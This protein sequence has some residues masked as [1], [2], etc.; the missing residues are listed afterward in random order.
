MVDT[1]VDITQREFE[2]A[3][4]KYEWKR[5]EPW[6]VEEAVYRIEAGHGFSV[7]IYSTISTDTG[8]SREKGTDAIRALLKYKGEKIVANAPKTLRTKNWKKN[9]YAKIDELMEMVTEYK[10]PDG[11]PM[12]KRKR[13]DGKGI[14]YGC[15]L[16][17]KC[18]YIYKGE[19]PL[20]KLY[21][22]S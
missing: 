2:K 12:V 10:D 20:D 3:L 14:F 17:P 4:D 5:I 8:V 15:A 7:W 22:K 1:Y 19:K 21:T 6:G 18:K 9:L 16:Y 11:H 13:K